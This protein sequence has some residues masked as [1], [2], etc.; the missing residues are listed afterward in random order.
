[1]HDLLIRGGT[2][3]DGTGAPGRTADVLVDGGRITAVAPRLTARAHRLL[4]ADGALVIPGFV[5]L[6]THSDGQATWDDSLEPS[7]SHGVTTVI[8]GNCG[9]GFAPLRPGQ[10]DELVQLMEGVE[11]I[12]GIALHEGMDWNWES[13]SDYLNVLAERRWSMDVGTQI[14]HG[15]LRAY[16]MGERGIRN[17]ASNTADIEAMARLTAEAMTA[18]A[19]G[20]STSRIC[21]CGCRRRRRRA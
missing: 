16:V 20:F 19:L 6:H 15:P 9:V 11:D 21:G 13:F 14:A 10:Q 5:D 4:D 18:G 7:A 3:V 2:V 12:P 8:T 1:V 17:E